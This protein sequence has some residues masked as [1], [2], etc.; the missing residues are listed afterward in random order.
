MRR[1]DPRRPGTSPTD[2]THRSETWKDVSDRCNPSVGD[3]EGHLGSMRSIGPR[4][5]RTSRT[6]A[7]HR[8]EMS[9]DL[10]DRI[11]ASIRDL[12]GKIHAMSLRRCD[13]RRPCAARPISLARRALRQE[14]WPR[15]NGSA[16][17]A[18]RRAGSARRPVQ[19]EPQAVAVIFSRLE[20]SSSRSSSDESP[21]TTTS[22]PRPP[23]LPGTPGSPLPKYRECPGTGT[24]PAR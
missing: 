22:R 24:P 19:A 11:A 23:E 17:A 15:S 10:R 14:K 2:A 21:T 18:A 12:V 20:A 8:S 4:H 13:G 9:Q 3:M 16:R 1:I 7:M 6:D 5:G